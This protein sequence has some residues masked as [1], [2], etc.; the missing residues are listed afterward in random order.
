MCML[1]FLQLSKLVMEFVGTYVFEEEV[2]VQET[3]S[4]WDLAGFEERDGGE[5]SETFADYT[6]EKGKFIQF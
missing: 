5:Y 4:F 6:I 3:A 2:V 1:G